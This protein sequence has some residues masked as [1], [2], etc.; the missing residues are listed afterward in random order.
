MNA[1]RARLREAAPAIAVPFT[2]ATTDEEIRAFRDGGLDVAEIRI[3]LFA[4]S[5]PDE[6]R[7][8]VRRFSALPTIVTIRSAAEGGRW[9]GSELERLAVFR[10]VASLADGVDIEWSSDEIRSDVIA[11]AEDADAVVVVS[12]HDF[13]ATPS[14]DRLREIG[15]AARATGADLVKIATTASDTAHLQTLAAF[16]LEAASAGVIVVGMGPF[17]PAS[18]VLLP[19]LGS[20]V[21]FAAGPEHA[22]AGQL[23][24]AETFE[25]LQR[26]SPEFAQ[27]VTSI[28]L[29]ASSS[30]KTGPGRLLRRPGYVAHGPGPSP[31]RDGPG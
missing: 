1:L 11:V 15:A 17:G 13:E 19:C 27:R 22:V 29:P 28:G 7:A 16:T 3:D 12:H 6:I 9:R 8:Q 18:R 4:T 25:S 30:E 24:F 31:R 20:R 2:D 5:D 23:S 26:F 14:L 21:T 10:R